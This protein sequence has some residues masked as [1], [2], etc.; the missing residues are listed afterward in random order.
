MNYNLV[1]A[2]MQN[3]FGVGD[4]LFTQ[5]RL[6]DGHGFGY[7]FGLMTEFIPGPI[8][9][10]VRAG[11]DDRRATLKDQ[12]DPN[13]NRQFSVKMT[14]ASIEPMLR[15]NLGNPN[16]HLTAGPSLG[17]VVSHKYDWHP[18][19]NVSPDLVNQPIANTINPV[20]GVGGGIGYD[21]NI[22]SKS[23][24]STRWY[25]TPFIEG[26]YIFNQKEVD[27]P[28][29]QQRGD[30]WATTTIRGGFQ[31]KF[32][33]V[34]AAPVEVVEVAEDVPT[35]DLAVRAPSA[36]TDER[37][38]TEWFPLR[39]YLFFDA[40]STQVPTKYAK[41]DPAQASSFTEKSLLDLPVAGA[42]SVSSGDR[43]QRQM[44]V[45]Y[46]AMN[47]YADRLRNNPSSTITLVGSAPT[48]AEGMAM[49]TAVRDYMVST[50]GIDASRIAVKGQVRPP[51]ASG[52]RAT[53]KEDLD[54][55]AEENRRVEVL[56]NDNNILKP[57]EIETLQSEPIDNDLI[58][59]VRG[60]GPI[61]SWTATITGPNGFNQTYGPFRGT[62][63]RLDAKPMLQ[64]AQSGRYTATVNAVTVNG[65][66]VTRSSDFELVKRDTP[67]ANG[68]RFSTLF[69]YDE[70]K[71]V[72][73]YDQFLRNDVAP[74]IPNGS[75]VVIHGH[76]D[77]IGLEDYNFDLS[78]RRATE[79]KNVLQDAL[80]KLG[81]TATFDTYGFGESEAR[82]PFTNTTPEGRYYDRTVLIEVIPNGQQ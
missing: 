23:A 58:L 76:T 62:S 25:L 56:S 46:N 68:E 40:N 48:E 29:T 18:G 74:Q 66:T 82:A 17:F 64:G 71:T 70:S 60:S 65:R 35:I 39:N 57:V 50:F 4:T 5:T 36:I 27:F 10:Q 75:T 42:S 80:T 59:N 61:Q 8:G 43:S 69:E 73:T 28:A 55:V 53:P 32:G 31:L 30:A 7:Y 24:G 12:S 37:R 78:S 16:L 3:L 2:G 19:D 45:Y 63:Q 26:S 13:N 9:F 22:N 41:L 15:V 47:I 77:K 49:A 52:T 6:G 79:T 21:W 38:V 81:R 14:Y 54:L 1:G 33:N 67:P 51:H 44:G 34:V 20:F 11:I 72:Q